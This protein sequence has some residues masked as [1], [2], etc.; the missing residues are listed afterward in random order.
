MSLNV[1]HVFIIPHPLRGHLMRTF[2]VVEEPSYPSGALLQDGVT[3]WSFLRS[4][5]FDS[6]R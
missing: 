4:T 5:E 2:I 1:F 3:T 6:F